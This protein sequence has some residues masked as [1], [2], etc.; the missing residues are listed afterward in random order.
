M[1]HEATYGLNTF[2]LRTSRLSLFDT[3]SIT[4]TPFSAVSIGTFEY[5]NGKMRRTQPIKFQQPLNCCE[6]SANQ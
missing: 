4:L 6:C 2:P 3:S 5:F 1:C